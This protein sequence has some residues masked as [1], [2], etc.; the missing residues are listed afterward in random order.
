MDVN[1]SNVLEGTRQYFQGLPKA[2][3]G[4]GGDA[5]PAGEQ[6]SSSAPT[7]SSPPPAPPPPPPATTT[8][9]PQGGPV[10]GAQPTP[11]PQPQQEPRPPSAPSLPPSEPPERPPSD[12]IEPKPHIIHK[13]TVMQQAQQQAQQQKQQSFLNPSQDLERPSSANMI[14]P[15]THIIHK[16]LRLPQEPVPSDNS[17]KMTVTPVQEEARI[18]P[19]F[20]VVS[21]GNTYSQPQSKLSP[22]P[23]MLKYSSHLPTPPQPTIHNSHYLS[24][25]HGTSQH[26]SISMMQTHQ[27]RGQS[28]SNSP[29]P[30]VDQPPNPS[31]PQK[32]PHSSQS[33]TSYSHP[34]YENNDTRHQ[35]TAPD[36]YLKNSQSVK[37]ASLPH[38]QRNEYQQYQHNMGYSYIHQSRS[39]HNP[40]ADKASLSVAGHR[41][42]SQS[43]QHQKPRASPPTV[44]SSMPHSPTI[45][46]RQYTYSQ[47]TVAQSPQHYHQSHYNSMKNVSQTPQDSSRHKI[48]SGHNYDY[49]SRIPTHKISSNSTIS[50]SSSS[51]QDRVPALS[52]DQRYNMIVAQNMH[53]SRQ[54][55]T[56][57]QGETSHH[58]ARAPVPTHSSKS[59]SEY[60]NHQ[61]K[62]QPPQNQMYSSSNNLH[63]YQVVNNSVE[64]PPAGNPNKQMASG[65]H[66][67]N[68]YPTS[69][70]K[71]SYDHISSKSVSARNMMAKQSLAVHQPRKTVTVTALVNQMNNS[72]RYDP[73][74]VITKPK[75]ESPLDL[76][77]KTVR[78]PAD[79]TAQDDTENHGYDKREAVLQN[80]FNTRDVAGMSSNSLHPRQKYQQKPNNISSSHKVDFLPDFNTNSV[81][82]LTSYQEANSAYLKTKN[83]EQLYPKPIPSAYT[84]KTNTHIDSQSY[85]DKYESTNRPVYNSNN[86]SR[87]I[88]PNM[89][90][91]D[92]TGTP[93]ND[94]LTNDRRNSQAIA[95]HRKREPGYLQS[96]IPQKIA[97]Y[98]SWAYERHGRSEATYPREMSAAHPNH[99]KTNGNS[100]SSV[101]P[102]KSYD[103][104]LYKKS[105]NIDPY[106]PKYHNQHQ[107]AQPHPDM[108]YRGYQKN[109]HAYQHHDYNPDKTLPVKLESNSY[110][111][112]L[113][114]ISHSSTPADKRVLNKLRLNLETKNLNDSQKATD[115]SDDC[116]IIQSDDNS[117]HSADFSDIKSK[118]M[119]SMTELKNNTK[120]LSPLYSCDVEPY[121]IQVPRAVDSI[122]YELDYT[123]KSIKIRDDLK[124]I[125]NELSSNSNDRCSDIIDMAAVLAARIR[126]KAE[127][128][129]FTQSNHF[130]ANVAK[131]NTENSETKVIVPP[132]VEP[133]RR[134][135]FSKSDNL[136]DADN[137]KTAEH[138]SVI[139]NSSDSVFD[140]PDSGSEN[141]IP[142]VNRNGNGKTDSVANSIEPIK[143]KSEKNFEEDPYWAETCDNFL[144]QLKFGKIKKTRR[145]K[146]ALPFST[147]KLDLVSKDSILDSIKM[148]KTAVVNIVDIIK[149]ENNPLKKKI[150]EEVKEPLTHD[151]STDSSDE[152]QPLINKKVKKESQILLKN[153]VSEKADD[154]KW[155]L[156]PIKSENG[157]IAKRRTKN[158]YSPECKMKNSKQQPV[159]SSDDEK[160]SLKKIKQENNNR[161]D[162]VSDSNASDSESDFRTV[163]NR[164]RL[165]KSSS[166]SKCSENKTTKSPNKDS[167][168]SKDDNNKVKKAGF[169]DGSDFRPGWEEEVYRY[170]R[171]LRMPAS[172]INV[173]RPPHWPRISTSLPD[174]DPCPNSPAPSTS[175]EELYIQ[176]SNDKSKQELDSDL[177]STSSYYLN[178]KANY[179]SEASCSTVISSTSKKISKGDSSI[180]DVLIQKCGKKDLKKNKLKTEFDG[181]R[182]I[183]KSVNSLEL[184]ATPN[185]NLEKNCKDTSKNEYVY[186]GSFRPETVTNFR[187]AFIT[188]TDGLLGAT[189]EFAPV[190]LKSRTR[191][192]TRVM[193]QR[194]TIKEVFGDERP[195]SAPPTTYIDEPT[196]DIKS[197]S[198]KFKLV[199]QKK[200]KKQISI[201]REGLRSSRLLK[202]NDPKGRSL[203][204]RK[205]NNFLKAL[206]VK[207]AKNSLFASQKLKKDSATSKC[208]ESG[209]RN[210]ESETILPIKKTFRRL[211][212]R[213]KLSS[214]FDYIRKKKKQIKKDDNN[215]K[216]SAFCRP[217]PESVQDIQREIKGWIINKSIGETVLHRA[218][219]LGFTVR[220][221]R[222]KV[223]LTFSIILTDIFKFQDCVAYCLEK[224][225]VPPS[226]RDNAGYTA[227]HEACS[228]GHLD[229]ARLLLQYGANVSEAAQGGIR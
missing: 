182:I 96:N 115:N 48:S 111:T 55:S 213:R 38:A 223:T 29:Y 26:R 73:S 114:H 193:K 181:P 49:A 118:K 129:G 28:Y 41:G 186:V 59:S 3:P 92:L 220:L 153:S 228:R 119:K 101:P 157:C 69:A 44:K 145:K 176:R 72:K 135:L 184:L 216:R 84:N 6:A 90:K 19:H 35:P 75:K 62:S 221:D 39:D 149:T 144:E 202:R 205:R 178:R 43:I 51:Y 225:D 162:R 124:N 218:A 141:D 79:S 165:R 130:N 76:S 163:A 168:K 4:E 172:L 166:M 148:E 224:L 194:A 53:M 217:S 95:D 16:P 123:P 21:E 227:L 40:E 174:L 214:G 9:Q 169:G 183:P 167:S 27:P 211:F 17:R 54:A 159:V 226:C 222:Q 131:A 212:P 61:L 164:L 32:I 98:D 105:E 81:E 139:R 117:M 185:L 13:A 18:P 63:Q 160:L 86:Y 52:M 127:L 24:R 107:A 47:K 11:P 25:I 70:V 15:P 133:H 154:S 229:I 152:D 151:S 1:F 215:R 177:E 8:P 45:P 146:S 210:N 60:Q 219:R 191:T 83:Y 132:K 209:T 42:Y 46:P 121:K 150:K 71:P 102:N 122:K 93:D 97:R 94:H 36:L 74:T 103:N 78:T 173:S 128:K 187:D 140:F 199:P 190:V 7:E 104:S 56:H 66:L 112:H 125:D 80:N 85:S 201:S 68:S 204:I 12:P 14:S 155:I 23:V 50:T 87:R 208:D 147:E 180:L 89:P 99:Y 200:I 30:T 138:T 109:N 33:A 203:R 136:K 5:A 34:A 100:L 20:A 189:Q 110:N 206:S 197:T 158:K 58:Y 207:K 37:S 192:E 65:Y 57:M 113:S 2:S 88:D 171:S 198:S 64:H 67:Q 31:V 106:N 195:A 143:I 175:T 77:V 188:N 156:N 91:I 196:Q 22:A 120:P 142:N 179:D 82:K 170:K 126:T 134:R 161:T 10:P 137:T 116:I 108:Y